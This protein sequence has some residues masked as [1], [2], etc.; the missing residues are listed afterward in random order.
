[1]LSIWS[2]RPRPLHLGLFIAAYVLACGFA[3]SLAIVPGT[4]ISIWPASGLFIATLVLASGSSWPWWVLGG[5]LAELFSN[6]LWFGSPPPAAFL[7]YIGNALEAMAGAWLVNRTLTRP[8]RLETLQ[9]VFAFVVLGAGI[10]PIVSATV[11]SATLAW[12][13]IQS[14]SFSTA[15]PLWWIGDAT[16]VLIV[17]PL[18]LVV[19]QS[20]RGKTRLSAAQWVEACVLGLIFLGVAALSLSGY[21]PFAYIIMPPLLWAAVRFEFKGAAVSL[22][23]LALITALFTITGTSQ[24]AG[25]PEFQKHKQVMLQLFLAISAFSAL[26]VAAISRQHQL[27]VL[28]LRQSLDTLRD[29]ERELSQLVDMVPSHVWRLTPDGEPTFFNKRMVDFLGLDVAD[30]D[31][32]GMSR[33]EAV[34]EATIHPEDAAGFGDALRHCLVSGGSFAMRYRLRRADGLYRWMSSRAEPM[35]DQSGRIVQWY[36]LCH[37]ID[38]QVHAEDAVRR[39]QQQLQQIIDAVPVR[40]WSVEP[41]GGSFYFNKRYQDHFRS[42]ITNFDALGEP[43]ID[44]LL[45]QLVHPEDAPDIQRTLRNCFETGDGSAMRFRWREKDD[46]YRWAECRVEPRR[47]DDGT[48]AEWYGVSLDIDEEVRA[49]EALRNR[50]R[51]LS[52]LVDMVPVQ[53]RRLTPEGEPVFFNKRLIDFFGLDVGDMDR[54]GMSRLAA[55]IGTLIHPDDAPMVLETIHHSLASGE[56]FSIK[57]RMRRVDGA[58]RWVDGRAEPLRDQSGAIMQWY[59]ISVDI[60]DEMRAQEA[61]RDRERELSQL[62]DM[63]PSLLW[64]LNPE[65]APTFFNKRLIDFLGLEMADMDRPGM[66]RLAALIEAAVH[67]DDAATLEEALNHSFAT[68]ERFSS[69]YRLRRADGVYRWVKGSAEPLRDESDRIVQ[70]YGLSHDIDDQL[71]VEEALRERERSLWQLVETLPAMID[72]AA[73]DGEPIYRSQ[74]LRDFLGYNLDELDG[75]GKTRLDG[76]LDA[77]VHPDD[78][79]GVKENYAHSLSTGEP[80]ARR[81]RLRRH[82]GEYRWV[83]TRAAPM[84]NAEGVIV[85]WNVI[86]LDID[87]EV[88]AEEDLRR[89]REGLARASQV[90][91]LAELSAS[92]AHEVNQPLAAVVANSHACQRWLMAEP[93]NMERAQRTVERIIRDANS[94][95]DVVSRIRALFKQSVDRRI[96]STLS[97]IVNEARNLMADEAWR[98]HVRMEVEVDP[99]LPPIAIDRVQIQQ[100]LINLIRNGIEAMDA[101]TGDRVVEIRVYQIGNILQTEISDRG[102]GIDFPEKMFEPFFTTKENGMGMGLAICRSIVELHGGRLWAEKNNPHGATLLFTLPIETKAAS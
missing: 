15:W 37:D 67:P 14:Q 75:T 42:V 97:G 21:L 86:C 65:G 77:G 100:V 31:K 69:Q 8:V 24:F 70:W 58:Y 84:R 16:G 45:Q 13:G 10:A 81:H 39:S 36:G 90:A 53:I 30:F 46:V 59:V 96:S 74:Q 88:H 85:Q 35:R 26:I 18:A 28:T 20:W 19:F 93:P 43:R 29:R 63:V 47:D 79:A 23:L 102:Q 73:P 6:F 41:T 56:P 98:R 82:D 7:I 50:E 95:A 80:Y 83:E 92:I 5:C 55:V 44:D 99:T 40:I 68:G 52:Q 60:D 9:D 33:L 51:E 76:T 38:D 101:T 2:H 57:Y 4:G 91:S 62:V 27:A 32:P 78:V 3:Q 22:A 17:A 61:L 25:D 64:R 66:S 87:G 48:V 94:A 72:C 11:G 12:F 71:R 34:L 89:V 54:P 1:M 49:L